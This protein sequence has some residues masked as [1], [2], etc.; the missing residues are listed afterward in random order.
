MTQMQNAHRLLSN[1]RKLGTSFRCRQAASSSSTQLIFQ[2]SYNSEAF[3]REPA[4]P[5]LE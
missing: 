5:D 1:W 3:L 2:A 4:A